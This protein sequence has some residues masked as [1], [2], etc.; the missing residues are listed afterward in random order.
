ML[1]A[2]VAEAWHK[3]EAVVGSERVIKVAIVRGVKHYQHEMESAGLTNWS[4]YHREKVEQAESMKIV[5]AHLRATVWPETLYGTFEGWHQ[6][7]REW[8][9]ARDATQRGATFYQTVLKRRALG[10]WRAEALQGR[11]VRRVATRMRQLLWVTAL[12]TWRSTA[13]MLKHTQVLLMRVC[14]GDRAGDRRGSNTG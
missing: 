8:H 7:G 5:E 9:N 1:K 4:E 11:C 10:M 3:W 2:A 14:A 6:Q 12:M 13:Q